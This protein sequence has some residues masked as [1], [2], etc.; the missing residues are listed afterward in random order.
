MQLRGTKEL[1][2]HP[3][4]SSLPDFSA[5][6]FEGATELRAS[7]WLWDFVPFQL[8]IC[9]TSSWVKVVLMPGRAVSVP[10]G[11]WHAVRSTPRSVAI[12][13]AVQVEH[14]DER[15]S[16]RRACRRDVQP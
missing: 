4:T 11:W 5:H 3:P 15:T 16:F 12:S 2:M 14:V 13:V 7:R 9:H 8:A 6:T 1:L 10:S